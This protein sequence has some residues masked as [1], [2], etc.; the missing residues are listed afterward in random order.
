MNQLAIF[1]DGRR[2]WVSSAKTY[3]HR[4]LRTLRIGYAEALGLTESQPTVRRLLLPFHQIVDLNI[5]RA[6]TS[7]SENQSARRLPI[8]YRP[9]R[10]P[11]LFAERFP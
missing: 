8:S 9:P 3:L 7:W 11:Q 6:F 1:F 5:Q 2:Q 4:L 10:P